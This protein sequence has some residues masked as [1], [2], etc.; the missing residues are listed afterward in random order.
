MASFN[1]EEFADLVETTLKKF[2]YGKFTDISH[3]LQD[4]MVY[5]KFF[6]E[7][8]VKASGGEQIS[9]NL[10]VNRGA[11]AR[12]VAINESDTVTISSHMDKAWV[13]WRFLT[14]NYSFDMREDQINSGPEQIVDM[15][16]VRRQD[17]DAEMAELME[18][19]FWQSPVAA[20]TKEPYGLQ[21]YVQKSGTAGFNG[22]VPAGFTTVANVPSTEAAWQNYTDEYT[23]VD[24]E[25]LFVK[26]RTAAWNCNFKHPVSFPNASPTKQRFGIYTHFT[27]HDK[28]V[29]E[30]ETRNDNLGKDVV[31]GMP[32]FMGNQIEAVPYL[33]SVLDDESVWGVDWNVLQIVGLNNFIMKES[34]PIVKSDN[35]N[36]VVVYKDVG[37]NLKCM[38]RRSLFVIRKAS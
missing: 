17:C 23:N 31:T 38:D 28:F 15:V 10:K 9:W 22:G 5:R 16:A 4:F 36:Q 2:D 21:Y 19:L 6:K 18:K 20:N 8:R 27:V 30:M 37:Y 33:T 7:E 14:H 11:P 25:D 26:M 29:R 34:K 12:A 13:P 3:D 35:H 24:S 32:L 1:A